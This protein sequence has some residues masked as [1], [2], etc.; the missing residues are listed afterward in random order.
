MVCPEGFS[1]TAG[2]PVR[3]GP[4]CPCGIL[5]KG[6]PWVERGKKPQVTEG[7]GRALCRREK[8]LWLEPSMHVAK[9]EGQAGTVTGWQ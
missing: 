9:P 5:L 7:I 6:L 3:A 8:L 4:A 1:K 2:Q